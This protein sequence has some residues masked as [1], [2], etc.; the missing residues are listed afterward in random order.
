MINYCIVGP[1]NSHF[2]TILFAA[3]NVLDMYKIVNLETSISPKLCFHVEQYTFAKCPI[4]PHD[5]QVLFKAGHCLEFAK[6]LL[7]SLR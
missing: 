6:C 3:A 4:L 7:E 1:E 2:N 5:L